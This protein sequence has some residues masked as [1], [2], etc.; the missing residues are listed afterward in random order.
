M[1]KKIHFIGIA[2]VAIAPIAKMLKD[3]GWI[4]TGSDEEVFDPILTYLKTNDIAW[5]EG[6]DASRVQDVDM[7]LI[8]GG[9][10]LKHSNNVELEEAKRLN[11]KIVTFAQILEEILVK[12]ESIVVTGTYGKT[13]TSG[14]LAYLL[15]RLNLNPSFMTGG[16][17][18][19]FASGTRNTNSKYSVLEGDEFAAA[20]GY[21]NEPKFIYYKPKYSLITAS[22]WDHLNLYPTEQ[23]FIDAFKKLLDKTV[24]NSGIA[25]LC[26]TGKNIDILFNEYKDKLPIYTYSIY[27]TQFKG[28]SH[29]S[30]SNIKNIDMVYTSFKVL[31][32]NKEVGEFKTQLIGN[33]NI[34]NDLG[35]IAMCDILQFD[36]VAVSQ[37]MS[38]YKGVRRRQEIRGINSKGSI[39]MDD[40]AH[41]AVKAQ[42]TLEALRSR[43]KQEKIVVIFDPH[44]SSLS[45]RKSLE[46]YAGAFDKAD[47]VY[48]PR[49][50]V[51]KRTN[52]DDRVYGIDIVNT[53]K[54]TQPN[55][56][57]APKDEILINNLKN[58]STSNTV[59]VFMSSGG[60]RNIIDEI[61]K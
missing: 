61:L 32:D 22:Q 17:P 13:T 27:D 18:I 20:F 28:F 29:Y 24:T 47:K 38:E 10:V 34:E 53:I 3:M 37:A 8:G 30:V 11:K 51:K 44:A 54:T 7:V 35:A 52:K 12:E 59:I 45:D 9:A 21:D 36:L 50:T 55:V 57:Y 16:Q 41:S 26:S 6:F 48:V 15:D 4:V 23:S 14:L 43:Y 31:R 40:L 60:W 25:L 56:E 58:D 49:V 39:V 33:H 46:W 1:N 42:S 5:Q 2:G 19:H